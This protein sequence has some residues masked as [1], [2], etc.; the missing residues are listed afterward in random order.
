MSVL[1]FVVAIGVQVVLSTCVLGA[2]LRVTGE[3]LDQETLLK[4]LGITLASFIF[5]MVP[6]IGWL[7]IVVW[8]AALMSIFELSFS[9]AFLIGIVCWAINLVLGLVSAAAI[10]A[11]G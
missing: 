11:L 5:A 6:V 8:L 2:A 10:G 1:F 7:S 9:E 3:D 4:C